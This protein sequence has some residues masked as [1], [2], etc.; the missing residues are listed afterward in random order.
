MKQ[1]RDI[2]ASITD[3]IRATIKDSKKWYQQSIDERTHLT[4][5]KVLYNKYNDIED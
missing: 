1:E 4:T 3:K 2:E 5:G